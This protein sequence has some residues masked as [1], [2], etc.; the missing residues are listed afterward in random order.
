MELADLPDEKLRNLLWHVVAKTPMLVGPQRDFGDHLCFDGDGGACPEVLIAT[1]DVPCA[2]E[3]NDPEYLPLFAEVH[4][5]AAGDPRAL[6]N[7]LYDLPQDELRNQILVTCEKRGISLE[8]NAV[9]IPYAPPAPTAPTD[10]IT[11][12][13]REVLGL[14]AAVIR[15]HTWK[16]YVWKPDSAQADMEELA[17]L[18]DKVARG[19]KIA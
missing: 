13:Q 17:D 15:K 8:P 2:D 6:A 1:R 4:Q 16:K 5:Y 18:L 11:K 19:D 3:Y 9:I 7:S 12:S 14:L 10:K